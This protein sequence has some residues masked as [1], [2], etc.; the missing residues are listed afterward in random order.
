MADDAPQTSI[1]DCVELSI[2]NNWGGLPVYPDGTRDCW[3][4]GRY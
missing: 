2:W 1:P 3:C 4:A